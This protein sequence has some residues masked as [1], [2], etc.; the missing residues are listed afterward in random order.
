MFQRFRPEPA[1]FRRNV[2]LLARKLDNIAA[3]AGVPESECTDLESTLAALPPFA[4]GR[5]AVLLQGIH[6]QA[7]EDNPAMAMAAHY[8]LALAQEVWDA[9]PAAPAARPSGAGDAAKRR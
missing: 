2:E 1:E 7:E 4:R 6:V 9:S 8:V 5:V 3:G